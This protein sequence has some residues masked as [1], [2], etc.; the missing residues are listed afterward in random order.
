MMDPIQIRLLGPIE[1]QIGV[2]RIITRPGRKT[3]ALLAYLAMTRR[4]HARRELYE[5]FCASA[6]DPPAALRWHLNRIRRWISPA[7]IQ[8]EG[9][10]LQLS[11]QAA[12]VDCFEFEHALGAG[13]KQQTV[14]ELSTA[15]KLFRGDF[16]AN[17]ALPDAPEFELWVLGERA[18]LRGLY[19]RGLSELI[20]QLI[21]Q[22]QFEAAILHAQQLVQSNPLLEQAHAHLIWLYAQTRQRQA[23]LQQFE[24]CREL[25]QRELAVEPMPELIALHADVRAGRLGRG[26]PTATAPAQATFDLRQTAGF[27]GRDAELEKIAQL[28][29]AARHGHGSVALIEAE[30]GGGKT[31]LAHEA[32]RHLMEESDSPVLL[33]V[34]QCYESTRALPYHPWI[35]L[36]E[37]RLAGLQEAALHRLS[38]F[39]LDQLTRLLPALAGRL[40]RGPISAPSTDAG[41]LE[42]LFAAVS[43]FLFRLPGTPPM[44]IFVDNLQWADE[45]SLRLFHFLARRI[46]Q[47]FALLAGAFRTEELDEVPALQ[48]LLSDLRR[49]S[50]LELRL[51]P[52]TLATITAL[53]AQLWPNL[54]EGYRPHVCAMLAKATGGNP[55]FVTE[56]LRELAHTS[57]IPIDVPV[58]PT[59]HALIGRRLGKLTESGRQ[60]L[61]AIAVL[62]LP[63][64]LEQAQQTSGRSE[65]ETVAAIDLGLRWRLLASEIPSR[66]TRYDF[67]HDLVRE[68]VL[69]QLRDARRRLLHRRAATMVA[70]AAARVPPA[71]RQELAGRITRHAIEGEVDLLVLTWAPLAAEHAKHLN[72]YT[73]ALTAYEIAFE[74]LTRL[75]ATN[76]L[77]P[78]AAAHHQLELLLNRVDVLSQLGRRAEESA[79]LQTAA[80]LLARQ[81]AARLE[82]AFCLAQA[83]YLSRTNDYASAV[84]WAQRAY[85]KYILLN[86][87]V[88]AA[89]CLWV[90]G[91]AKQTLGENKT[92]IRLLEESLVLYR[93]V[94][95]WRGANRCLTQA[96]GCLLDLGEM[97]AG[98]KQL[99]QCLELAEER[100]D[101]VARAGTCSVLTAAWNFYYHIEK[102]R[103]YAEETQRLYHELGNDR[104]AA[105]VLIF[106]AS[107]YFSQ[108]YFS[109]ARVFVTQALNEAVPHKYGWLEGWSA[110]LLGRMELNSGELGAAEHWL[111]YAYQLR[112]K[113]G[114][115]QN[116]ISDLAWLGRLRLAQSRPAEALQS[117]SEALTRLEALREQVR[118]WETSD[119]FLCHAETLAAAGQEAQAKIYIQHA[120]QDLMQFAEQISDPQV[121]QNFLDA[122]LNV[123]IFTARESCRTWPYPQ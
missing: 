88:W 47:T 89:K 48:T 119:I 6:D 116:L 3:Q 95:D 24:R 22:E 38:P 80:Q 8:V 41:E 107:T 4:M 30:A 87:S 16:L 46:P 71:R 79:L 105:Q 35:E 115:A 13:L 96:A 102:V 28:W 15:V 81:P 63:V 40:E 75:Q 94:G 106:L 120:Y 108:G 44:I 65:E 51:A 122:P 67:T 78:A 92:A 10:R 34:G 39:W 17:L 121:K 14:A 82:A 111:H 118:V 73:D 5:R 12:R 86:D 104:S 103:L 43:E 99:E 109:Q 97:D 29:Q 54:P 37:T 83:T 98:L 18:R 77:D 49:D 27:V 84:E 26:L 1:I 70:E 72:G 112:H 61:Q 76:A 21:A 25:L 50:L 90:S 110:H 93:A 32:R 91:D 62:D 23:A 36:L 31:R 19:E 55:L 66:P 7:A 11:P 68:A 123:R 113:S 85:E 20:A 58:P 59:V 117:T 2:R 53:A 56:V 60:V 42:R 101:L 100:S 74:A 33:L 114:Q 69:S 9:D 57:E 45:A 64:T 52:L